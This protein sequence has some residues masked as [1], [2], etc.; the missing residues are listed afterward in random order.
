MPVLRFTVESGGGQRLDRACALRN[1]G[2]TRS[3]LK[4]GAKRI[5]VNGKEAKMSRAVR[6][7]DEVL[8]EWEDPVPGDILPEDIELKIVFEND[9]VTVVNKRQGMVTHPAAG[10]WSG[11]LVNALLWHWKREVPDGNQRPGIVHRLD[12]DTS[13]LII[14]AKNPEAEASLQEAFKKR[15]VTKVYASLLTR[16]PPSA[17]GEIRTNI[18]RD[19]GNRK[20]FTWTDKA[21]RGKSA[22]TSYRVL[23]T[24]GNYALVLFRLHTGRTHQIRVHSKYLGCPILGDP[25][26][27]KRDALFPDATL[28]LHAAKLVIALPGEKEPTT[29]TA[30]L[31]ARFKEIV[32]ALEERYAR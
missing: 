6:A 31:P 3:R 11:T 16:V 29:F 22:W 21:E 5:L 27:G 26:Y 9:D 23:K 18:V 10:N 8:V 30:P 32:T 20:R 4:N 19:P 28:M 12:K 1:P 17:K 13:G 15:T 14:T 24:W 7:G 25:I 2:I